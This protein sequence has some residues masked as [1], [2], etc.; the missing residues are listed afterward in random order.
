MDAATRDPVSNRVTGEPR[1]PPE[2]GDTRW[3][4]EPV[5]AGAGE[6]GR[7]GAPF[8]HT[9]SVEAT[10]DSC[11]LVWPGALPEP[12]DT[13]ETQNEESSVSSQ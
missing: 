6:E 7:G 10:P 5:T 4:E 11:H 1:L 13:P 2:A 12:R 8:C 9:A 3:D